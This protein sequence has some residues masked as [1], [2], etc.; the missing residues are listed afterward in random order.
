M[1]SVFT[2][3]I[4]KDIPGHFV[5][6]DDRVIVIMTIQPVKPGHVLVIPKEEVDYWDDLDEDLAE[7]LMRIAR[8]AAKAIKKV[9]GSLRVGFMIAGFEVP[10]T[11]IHLIPANS[12]SD[13]S[14]AGL[15]FA[16]GDDLADMCQ[17]IKREWV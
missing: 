7:H 2:Q 9:T 17:K 5:Y 1:A 14:L 3:I 10:H 8:K 11:H 16:E 13:F 15:A 4:Q 6:E 12:M